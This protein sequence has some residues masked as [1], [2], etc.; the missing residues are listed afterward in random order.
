M[1]STSKVDSKSMLRWT[2]GWKFWRDSY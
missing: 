1:T 2:E